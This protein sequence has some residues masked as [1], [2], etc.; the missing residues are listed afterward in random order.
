M[1]DKIYVSKYFGEDFSDICKLAS[2]CGYE[3]V[4]PSYQ[5][6]STAGGQV[7]SVRIHKSSNRNMKMDVIN[8]LANCAAAILPDDY[9]SVT[10]NILSWENTLVSELGI[11]KLTRNDLLE[12]LE[13]IVI[14]FDQRILSAAGKSGVIYNFVEEA[15]KSH[16]D[17]AIEECSELLK[18][19][20]KKKRDKGD[21]DNIVEEFV[22]VVVTMI[23]II[24][25]MERDVSISD[26]L[27][28]IDEKQ[29]RTIKRYEESGE[30]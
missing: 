30:L 8:E 28:L 27:E 14:D 24:L 19:L 23:P 1:R 22:D 17:Y 25:N 18:E 26:I 10:P 16:E 29:E 21:D 7:V 9:R 20:V 2:I 12:R 5:T 15:G 6:T 13:L 4:K 3:V 11:Q